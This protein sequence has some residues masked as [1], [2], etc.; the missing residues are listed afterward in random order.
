MRFS[1]A[2]LCLLASGS[3]SAGAVPGKVVFADDSSATSR[4]PRI[5]NLVSEPAPHGMG[6]TTDTPFGFLLKNWIVVDEASTGPRRSFSC[7]P[8]RA[9]ATVESSA[10]QSARSPNSILFA[11][12]AL[13]SS[14]SLFP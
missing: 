2:C 6:Y 9:D 7:I 13:P 8:E 4:G 12:V 1:I 10:Q 14:R 5:K 11:G 3:L